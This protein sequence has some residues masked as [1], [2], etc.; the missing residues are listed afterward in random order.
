MS[1]QLLLFYFRSTAL[2]SDIREKAAAMDQMS[3]E[4][5]L[6]SAKTYLGI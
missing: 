1:T 3:F 5:S 6:A 4:E 2:Y